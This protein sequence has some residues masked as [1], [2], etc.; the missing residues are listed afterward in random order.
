MSER[1]FYDGLLWTMVAL[2]GVTFVALFVI[3]APY[4]R[5]ERAGWGPTIRS[6]V[7]WVVMEAPAS[8]AFFGFYLAGEARAQPVP[9]VLLLLWQAHYV[10]RAFVY[11]F[12]RRGGDKPMP[13]VIALLAI[14]FNVPN[15]YLNARFLSHFARYPTAWLV[16]PRFFA[17]VA[18]FVAGFVVNRHADAVLSRLRAPGERGYKIP[19]G[20]LYRLVSAPNYL[21]EIVEWSGF[22]LAAWSPAAAVFVLYTIANLVPRAWA[23]HRWYRAT[24]ADYPTSRRAIVP[25]I[26]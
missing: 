4:G 12:Q 10:H 11:P 3:T 16:D 14:A 9:L 25:F 8:L 26:F 21:G 17:G 1:A 6:T 15:A 20:G 19:H 22:A 18:L 24:F 23:N 5:H 13:L 2:S 7:G